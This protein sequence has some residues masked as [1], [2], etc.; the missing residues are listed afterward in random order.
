MLKSRSGM[1][2]NMPQQFVRRNAAELQKVLTVVLFYL[3]GVLYY[4][5]SEGWTTADCIYFITV[6]ITTVGYGVR[7]NMK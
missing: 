6:S 2:G 4:K 1:F 7:A 5:S 3:V